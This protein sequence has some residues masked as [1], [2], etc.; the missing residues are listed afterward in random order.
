VIRHGEGE[1]SLYAHLKT[2]SVRVRAG[3]AVRQG[4]PIARLGHSG[5]STEPHLHF[6]V[7]DGPDPLRCAGLPVRFDAI[8]LPFADRPRAPQSG[9]FVQTL[10]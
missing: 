2:G 9:D 5:N 10:R 3:D 6:Q 1:F 4:Q 8:A 7:C